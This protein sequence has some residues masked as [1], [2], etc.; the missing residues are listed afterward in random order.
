MAEEDLYLSRLAKIDALRERGV[1]PWPVRFDRTHRAG[2]LQ[3][4]FN[5]LAAGSD[6]GTNVRVAGRLKSS[7]GQGKL[8]FGQSSDQSRFAPKAQLTAIVDDWSGYVIGEAKAVLDGTWHSHDTWGGIK[9]GMVVLAPFTNMPDAVKALAEETKAGIAR[10]TI[11]QLLPV[12]RSLVH[13]VLPLEQQHRACIG[14]GRVTANGVEVDVLNI[15]AAHEDRERQSQCQLQPV[16]QS[17][18]RSHQPVPSQPPGHPWERPGPDVR[19][20]FCRGQGGKRLEVPLTSGL[21]I[22]RIR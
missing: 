7:R 17:L 14:P 8:A 2:E 21:S 1:D 20:P 19:E 12:P 4:T 22:D 15:A 5:D 11:D 9:D 3:E 18:E 6:S 16:C 13:A 10:G